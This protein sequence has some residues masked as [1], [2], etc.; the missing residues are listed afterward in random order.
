VWINGLIIN[1]LGFNKFAKK[2]L[3]A[4]NDLIKHRGPDDDIFYY[5]EANL[6][7][8]EMAMR[9]PVIIDLSS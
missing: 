5:F 7:T 6:Y 1:N 8:I 4:M 9:R 2:A 3:G